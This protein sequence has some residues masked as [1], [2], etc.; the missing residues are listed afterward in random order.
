MLP[1][2]DMMMRAQNGAAMD[3][4]AK[5]FNLAQEQA[6]QA[7]AALMPAFSSGLKRT[8]SNPYD[9]SA[10]MSS[11]FSG[12]YAQYFDD[13]TKAFT[14]QGMADGNAVLDRLFGSKEVT[15]AIAEQAAQLT[16][17]GQEVLRQMMPAM[18]DS[19]MGGLF[20]Q[21]TGQVSQNPFSPEAMGKAT[22]QWLEAIGFAPKARPQPAP[23]PF[24]TPMFQAFRSMWGLEKPTQPAPAPNPFADNP[25]A[26]AFQEMMAGAFST[27]AGEPAASQTKPSQQAKAPEPE[28]PQPKPEI[29][30]FKSMLNSMFD[31]GVEVQKA[32]QK[33][34]E[35]IFE[36]YMRAGQD[37]P[38]APA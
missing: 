11:M 17:I 30:K 25:F 7:M 37:T 5:Q 27:P 24:D 32:Y 20:K 19:I 6:A 21:M 34:M 2:F 10:L 33:N 1:L 29:E 8:S 23:M 16:G 12:A 38:K 26:K 22:Q 3:A 28:T 13:I 35:A 4:M 15:R 31:S 14:P 9:F 18:A 36:G